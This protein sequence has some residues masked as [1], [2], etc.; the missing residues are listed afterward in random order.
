MDRSRSTALRPSLV[1]RR[2]RAPSLLPLLAALL[3]A[4]GAHPALSQE[5]A[6]PACPEG[7]ISRIFVDNH[8]VFDPSD[9]D[10]DP[11]FA[12]AYR[13][14]NR[15]HFRTREDVIRR[16]VL[17]RE[18]DCYAPEVLLDSE[19]ILRSSD[20]I[21]DAD[22][23]GIRQPDGSYHVI[24]DTDD[25]WSTR[26][27]ARID[28]REG[29]LAGFR[30]REDNLLGTGQQ[31]A[32]SYGQRHGETVYG[33]S[34]STPQ[35]LGT[36]VDAEVAWSRTAS[37]YAV[38]EALTYPFRGEGGRWAFRQRL[39]HSDRYFEYLAEGEEGHLRVLFPEQRRS[40]EVGGVFR[41]G[42]RGNLTLFGLALTGERIV[43]PDGIRFRDGEEASEEDRKLLEP[44]GMAFDSV[45]SVRAVFL[46]GQRNVYFVRR[47]ALDAVR[48]AED[49]R[50]GVEAELGIGRSLERLS[51]DDDLALDL[52]LF[53]AG[54]LPGGVVAG[55]RAVLEARRDYA[56]P[57][58]TMEWSNVFGQLETWA[59]WRPS[60]GSRHTLV[61]AVDAAGGWN[62]S[63]PFQT[64]LGAWSGLRGYPRHAFAGHRRVVASLEDRVYFGWPFPALFD[65]GGAAFVDAGRIW[66][67]DDVYGVDSPLRVSV[68]AGLRAAFPPG[69]R[70]TYRLDVAV[71]VAG[72]V[73]VRDVVVSVGV[74]QAIGRSFRD[75][76]HIRR[77]S[78]RALPASLF[79][80]PD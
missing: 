78:R 79:S 69:S 12:W 50:L 47:S 48:G 24:V 53:V 61:A 19:R 55:G 40:A 45:S 20:Y 13:M 42:R 43:Y 77:S 10:L 76:P 36:Q 38:A 54:E 70:R 16:E 4:V 32:A 25:E 27:E 17:F 2:T 1:H 30:L 80:F 22:I 3:A 26:L 51:T 39:E 60:P 14:A 58:E 7:R 66:R 68:G 44:V 59:Y 21:D 8:G 34:F 33:A 5:P 18:G 72:G 28:S 46:A 56:A 37:G 67:G 29:G 73:G 23:Y 49:V 75:D 31:L 64:T 63:V 71:P 41:L 11:R 62:V 52:G 57:P 9:P 6:P 74:G 35:L 15:L 65:L